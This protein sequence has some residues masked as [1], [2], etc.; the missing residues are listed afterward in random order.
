PSRRLI[1]IIIS[2]EPIVLS[3]S[4]KGERARGGNR[5]PRYPPPPRG[6]FARKFI[7]GSRVKRAN[8]RPRHRSSKGRATPFDFGVIHG[9]PVHLLTCVTR[10]DASLL[11]IYREIHPRCGAGPEFDGALRG[12]RRPRPDLPSSSSCRIGRADGDADGAPVPRSSPVRPL[13]VFL[14]GVSFSRW[15]TTIGRV[16]WYNWLALITAAE[17]VGVREAEVLTIFDNWTMTSTVKMVVCKFGNDG[18][19]F[20]RRFFSMMFNLLEHMCCVSRISGLVEW[21]IIGGFLV[22]ENLPRWS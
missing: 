10:G 8:A 9:S 22:F 17:N 20:K 5:F 21:K 12:L 15:T 11:V 14:P 7:P 2:L 19:V 16:I 3:P 4:G 6:Q 13:A 18:R 1:S